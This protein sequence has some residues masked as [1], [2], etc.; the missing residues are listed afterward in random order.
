VPFV[1]PIPVFSVAPVLPGATRIDVR[2]G[3]NLSLRRGTILGEYVA[4]KGVY[5]PYDMAAT[6]GRQAARAIL[7][8][9]CSTDAN[10]HITVASLVPGQGPMADRVFEKTQAFVSG[11][12]ACE[13]LVGLDEQVV[14]HLGRLVTGNVGRGILRMR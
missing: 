1:L 3:A 7:Q 9:D 12:F 8:R 14:G 5:G 11:S 4:K 10:G 6:D 2:I 13:D